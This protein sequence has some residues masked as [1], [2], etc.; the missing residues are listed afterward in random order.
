MK[1]NPVSTQTQVAVPAIDATLPPSV[2]RKR[3][4]KLSGA[5]IVGLLLVCLLY[6][7]DAADE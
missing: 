6:T 5:G 3:R 2:P 4:L 1:P 7:S